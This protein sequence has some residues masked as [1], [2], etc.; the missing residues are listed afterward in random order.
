[1]IYNIVYTLHRFCRQF[2]RH[3]ITLPW[4]TAQSPE[5]PRVAYRQ[6]TH[7]PG[8]S[9][10]AN[11][12]NTRRRSAGAGRACRTRQCADQAQL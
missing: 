8:D 5:G 6:D 9:D 4:R 1:M 2:S 11:H 12:R 3:I 7:L 10:D